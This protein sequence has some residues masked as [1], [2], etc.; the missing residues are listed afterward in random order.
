[1]S[2]FKK[3]DIVR[4]TCNLRDTSYPMHLHGIGEVGTVERVLGGDHYPSIDVKIGSTVDA[5]FPEELEV[6]Q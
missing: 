4:V 5:F 6:I 1:M 3:G 2:A